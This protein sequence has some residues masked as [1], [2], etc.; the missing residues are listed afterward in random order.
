MIMAKFELKNFKI[1]NKGVLNVIYCTPDRSYNRLEF[2][3]I[4]ISSLNMELKGGEKPSVFTFNLAD[5]FSDTIMEQLTVKPPAGW[6]T[7]PVTIDNK[8]QWTLTCK[9]DMSLAPG[10]SLDFV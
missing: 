4:N 9:A 2:S 5:L 6:E 8:M 7:R 1:I 10:A 3:I